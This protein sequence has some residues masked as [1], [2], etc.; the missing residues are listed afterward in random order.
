MYFLIFFGFCAN[1]Y[2]KKKT[3]LSLM[4]YRVNGEFPSL[5]WGHSRGTTGVSPGRGNSV[6]NDDEDDEDFSDADNSDDTE[7]VDI[8]FTNILMG[9]SRPLLVKPGANCM[10]NFLRIVNFF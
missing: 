2:F 3:V 6:I 5:I 1:F 9:C 4:A 7:N 8:G 10:T